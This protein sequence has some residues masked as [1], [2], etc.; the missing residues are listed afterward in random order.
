MS[1]CANDIRTRFVRAFYPEHAETPHT[2]YRARGLKPG[3]IGNTAPYCPVC[4]A[5]D[6]AGFEL[7]EFEYYTLTWV[8]YEKARLGVIVVWTRRP[9]VEVGVMIGQTPLAVYGVQAAA[10]GGRTLA[11]IGLP[12]TVD[13]AAELALAR[14]WLGEH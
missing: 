1:A 14:H 6:A 12:G 2:F 10:E 4:A 9:A 3:D 5:L 11:V 8:R 13:L 7:R